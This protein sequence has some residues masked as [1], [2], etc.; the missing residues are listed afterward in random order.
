MS[1]IDKFIEQ[2]QSK[3]VAWNHELIELQARI[4]Q[5]KGEIGQISRQRIEELNSQLNDAQ[6]KISELTPPSGDA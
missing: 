3:M 2:L 6:K 1:D 4:D 5:A